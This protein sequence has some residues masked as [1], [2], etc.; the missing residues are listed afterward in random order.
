[1]Q[2]TLASQGSDRPKGINHLLNRLE[3]RFTKTPSR[4]QQV[5]GLGGLNRCPIGSL[6]SLTSINQETQARSGRKSL[7]KTLQ[8]HI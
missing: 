6:P 8:L 4:S 1:M 3:Q 5:S 7:V 2:K